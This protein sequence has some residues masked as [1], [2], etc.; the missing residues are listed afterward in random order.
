MTTANN[1]DISLQSFINSLF[2]ASKANLDSKVIDAIAV[3]AINS[4][5]DNF[6]MLYKG[7]E[8]SNPKNIMLYSIKIRTALLDKIIKA[9]E[10]TPSIIEALS[11]PDLKIKLDDLIKIKKK[12]TY[13]TGGELLEELI[14]EKSPKN[15][16]V[17]AIYSLMDEYRKI[18]N[19]NLPLETID[20]KEF[21]D[22]I[23]IKKNDKQTVKFTDYRFVHNNNPQIV[24]TSKQMDAVSSKSRFNYTYK[25]VS[26]T[27]NVKTT[28]QK[29]LEKI[30]N[31][32]LQFLANHL[33]ADF[34]QMLDVMDLDM[35]DVMEKVM[36]FNSS[37][38]TG[39]WKKFVTKL[40]I[41]S[42]Y[43][44]SS[45]KDKT[46]M[47]KMF[48]EINRAIHLSLK[49]KS[50]SYSGSF[51]SS[52]FNCF[53]EGDAMNQAVAKDIMLAMTNMDKAGFTFSEI[54]DSFDIFS[55]QYTKGELDYKN[56]GEFL[57]NKLPTKLTKIGKTLEQDFGLLK[58]KWEK[59]ELEKALQ[60]SSVSLEDKKI[61]VKKYKI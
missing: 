53:P 11:I 45:A 56:T 43:E 52:A 14:K 55:T 4:G 1:S 18:Y 6:L 42:Y 10:I 49:P 36:K 30:Y 59:S 20:I 25:K 47:Q 57:F 13:S 21:K 5:F 32:F 15:E 58:S 9:K 61:S 2:V 37:E 22:K 23:N 46:Q 54:I 40:D 38:A 19:S 33:R 8:G 3:K 7:F 31:V 17:D 26:L 39:V 34:V 24:Y 44:E 51:M 50:N 29:D 12:S 16:R 27:K 35:M 60:T 41:K 28:D 48:N